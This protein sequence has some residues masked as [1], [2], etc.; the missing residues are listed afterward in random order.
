MT[1]KDHV[2]QWLQFALQQ[3]AAE[4]YLHRMPDLNDPVALP[5]RLMFGFNDPPATRCAWALSGGG[6]K[7]AFQLGAMLY[8]WRD[9]RYAPIGI[10]S[11]SVGSV[12]ALAVAERSTAWINKLKSTWLGL[13][14]LDHMYA[15]QPW[16][17]ELDGIGL[18]RSQGLSLGRIVRQSAPR[19]LHPDAELVSRADP[20][21]GLRDTLDFVSDVTGFLASPGGLLVGAVAAPPAHTGA[22]VRAAVRV[23]AHRG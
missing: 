5:M 13:K 1:T 19:S 9:V 22:A 6:A 20:L 2:S 21:Q 16:V 8:L 17:V 15:V 23:V 11:T 18:L 10:A 12:N 14:N 3:L 7:G 4:S